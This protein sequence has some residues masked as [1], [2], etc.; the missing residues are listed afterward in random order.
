MGLMS[1][2]KLIKEERERTQLE[3]RVAR[4]STP[5]LITWAEQA[6]YPIE[7]NLSSFGRSQGLAELNE[8][9]MGAE[10]LLAIT[11]ELKRRANVQRR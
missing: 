10:A 11:T 2:V 9:H 7:R 3:K 8:A 1:R 4:I 5:D 6:V